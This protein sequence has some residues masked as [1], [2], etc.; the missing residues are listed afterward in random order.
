MLMNPCKR[1]AVRCPCAR[2]GRCCALV[3]VIVVVVVTCLGGRVVRCASGTVRNGE[4]A[5]GQFKVMA[6]AGPL[7][8]FRGASHVR[9][10]VNI[11]VVVVV[12]VC[13]VWVVVD[14]GG[15]VVERVD[16]GHALRTRHAL[17]QWY[18]SSS[19]SRGPGKPGLERAKPCNVV[20]I[21]LHG[22]GLY[23]V[24]RVDS[25]HGSAVEMLDE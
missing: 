20:V 15:D 21:L 18:W 3:D 19:R 16:G 10:V 23:K 12:V 9:V 5:P 24:Q 14:G 11:A 6:G 17:N 8:P 7:P 13:D 4:R 1:S 22:H 25:A 2:G